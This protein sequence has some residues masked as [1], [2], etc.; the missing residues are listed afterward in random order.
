MSTGYAIMLRSDTPE[1]LLSI[2]DGYLRQKDS[3]NFILTRSIDIGMHFMDLEIVRNKDDNPWK[4]SIPTYVVM[5]IADLESEV[6]KFG[7]GP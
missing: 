1:E 6:S 2:L 3:L 5:A 7:F 4:L